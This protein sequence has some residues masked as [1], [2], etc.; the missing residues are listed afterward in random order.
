M[1]KGANM[2]VEAVTYKE[3]VDNKA[4]NLGCLLRSMTKDLEHP[5]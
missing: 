5:E 4:G 1:I 2:L 3:A